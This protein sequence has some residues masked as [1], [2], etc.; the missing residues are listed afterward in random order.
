MRPRRDTSTL[1]G[2]IQAIFL[3]NNVWVIVIMTIILDT[4]TKYISTYRLLVLNHTEKFYSPS[5]ETGV[6]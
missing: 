4:E 6:A 3:T 5:D 2:G 1:L